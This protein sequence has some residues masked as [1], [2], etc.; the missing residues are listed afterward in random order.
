MTITIAAII[1]TRNRAPLAIA[2]MQS[3]LAQD[4]NLEIFVSDNSTDPE[5]LHRF[6]RTEPRIRYLR[7][8]ADLSMPAHWDWAIRHVMELSGASHFTVHYDR[9]VSKPAI[10][11]ELAAA[12]SRRPDVLL[13][14]S[15][16][17]IAHVPPPLRLWQAPWTGRTFTIRTGRV[18]QLVVR[19]DVS[20]I[21]NALPLLSNCIVPRAVFNTI[22][23]RFGDVC[24]SIAPDD[25]FMV[26]YLAL[27]DRYLHFDRAAGILYGSTRSSGLGYLRGTGGDFGDYRT[28]WDDRPWLHAAPVP[29]ISLGANILFHEYELV[30]R[31]T[32]D[33]LPPLDRVSVMDNLGAGLQWIED[34]QVKT[35]L[36]RILRERGWDGAEP[37]PHPTRPFLAMVYQAVWMAF[38]RP[39]GVAPSGVTGFSFPDDE[40]ALR[41]GL[42]HP[43]RAQ[44]HPDHLAPFEAEATE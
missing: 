6:C 1:P 10:W 40:A 30:R 43:R 25:S 8:P 4:V 28:R 14:F 13:S 34:P 22:V 20:R 27:Y 26:R 16:D 32:G 9:K 2:A 15:H 42:K 35:D 44:K 11:A 18:A 17:A 21:S 31:A 12:V 38:A 39:F 5:P 19:G 7:S 36:C 33:R 3:L 24:D 29:G 37:P 23:E 41:F